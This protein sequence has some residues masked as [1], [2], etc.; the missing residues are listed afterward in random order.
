MGEA[1]NKSKINLSI[2]EIVKDGVNLIYNKDKA[3]NAFNDFFTGIRSKINLSINKTNKDFE[4]YLTDSP[5][6][7]LLDLGNIGPI[8]VNDV[9]KALPNKSSQDLDG[10]SL[11]LIKAIST[12]IAVPLAHIFNLSFDQGIFPKSLKC[13]RTVPVF[14]SGNKRFC[15]NYRPISLVPTLSKILEK[16]TAIKLFNH[17]DLNKLLYKHQY[18]FQ[19]NKQTEHNLIHLLNFVSN[20]INNKKYCMGIFLDIKKAF[21]CVPH[22]ILFKKLHYLGLR[23]TTLNWFKSYLSG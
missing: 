12:I 22:D 14:K 16:I 3:F 13:S 19:K 5:D 4:D 11:K 1:I 17:L 23:G 18:G 21:D 10:I 9:I 8:H 2:P 6:T 20:G 7:P 15:D